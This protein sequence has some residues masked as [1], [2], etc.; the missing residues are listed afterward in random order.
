MKVCAQNNHGE[1]DCSGIAKY[2]ATKNQVERNKYKRH[3]SHMASHCQLK[4]KNL[5]ASEKQNA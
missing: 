5:A 1:L 2:P 4:E 3:T